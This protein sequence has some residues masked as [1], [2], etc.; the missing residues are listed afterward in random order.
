MV[1]SRFIWLL[2]AEVGLSDDTLSKNA[3]DFESKDA[4][5]E[6]AVGAPERMIGCYRVG[7]VTPPPD[8]E[9]I[10]SHVSL[11]TSHSCVTPRQAGRRL[12]RRWRLKPSLS[13]PC[14][15]TVESRSNLLAT[16]SMAARFGEIGRYRLHKCLQCTLTIAKGVRAR[17]CLESP[18][19]TCRSPSGHSNGWDYFWV[20]AADPGVARD[21]GAAPK[22]RAT[23]GSA[24]RLQNWYPPVVGNVPIEIGRLIC[25]RT[26]VWWD[27]S[28]GRRYAAGPLLLAIVL[29]GLRQGAKLFVLSLDRLFIS[30]ITAG[31]AIRWAIREGNRRSISW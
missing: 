20:I 18:P 11:H 21:F 28:L 2:C 13:L 26:N 14:S 29:V 5:G 4:A 30:L 16:A 6:A 10:S 19:G 12:A 15:S 8:L 31:P 25:Q 3:R 1:I 17:A 22:S 23:P 7:R 9:R 27:P 24:A